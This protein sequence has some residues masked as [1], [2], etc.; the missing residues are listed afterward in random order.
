MCE[1]IVHTEIVCGPLSSPE[2]GNVMVSGTG[3]GAEAMYTC[4]TGYSI[5]GESTRVCENS[6]SPQWSGN[7]P[8]CNSKP[9]RD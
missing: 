1:C 9:L 8:V 2:N 7:A 3:L 4:N 5:N 6:S